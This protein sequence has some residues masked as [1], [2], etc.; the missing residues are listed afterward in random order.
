M[1]TKLKAPEGVTSA[2]FGGEEFTVKKGV[3]TVPDEAA[4]ALCELGF[5]RIADA[6]TQGAQ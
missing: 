4:A 1:T 2:S 3:V 5:V 6:D